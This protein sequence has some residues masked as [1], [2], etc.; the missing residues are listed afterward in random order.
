M[1][2]EGTFI[3]C[4]LSVRTLY[5]RHGATFLDSFT[6]TAQRPRVPILHAATTRRPREWPL[7]VTLVREYG[8]TSGEY[9]RYVYVYVTMYFR[10]KVRN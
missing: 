8:S 5:T 2:Q 4:R 3:P 7:G 1:L 10:K 6:R 9:F